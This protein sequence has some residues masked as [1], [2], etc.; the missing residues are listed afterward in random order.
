MNKNDN[1]QMF[2]PIEQEPQTL[3]DSFEILHDAARKRALVR[4]RQ[5]KK[6][7]RYKFLDKDTHHDTK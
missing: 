3:Q 1:E 4:A 6:R 5:R 7:D 2:F